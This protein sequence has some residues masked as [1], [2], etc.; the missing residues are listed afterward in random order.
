[1]SIKTLYAAEKYDISFETEGVVDD[2][3]HVGNV[4]VNVEDE[5]VG[6]HP[7]QAGKAQQLLGA[8]SESRTGRMF[9][10]GFDLLLLHEI[11][12]K[13]ESS[14]RAAKMEK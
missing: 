2:V 9:D 13:V 4:L 7:A 10:K 6:L 8:Q 1:M 11:A 12:P 5:R 14:L 3:I